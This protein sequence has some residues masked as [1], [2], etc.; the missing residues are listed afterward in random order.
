MTG[1]AGGRLSLMTH[2]LFHGMGY[3]SAHDSDLETPG[4]DA[5]ILGRPLDRA[6]HRLNPGIPRDALRRAAR[7]V[8]QPPHE[9]PAAVNESCHRWLTHGVPV[10]YRRRDEPV[11]D[12]IRLVDFEHPENNGWLTAYDYEIRGAG[13]SEI[14]DLVLFVNGLPLVVMAY[15][16]A[17]AGETGDLTVPYERLRDWWRRFPSLFHFNALCIITDGRRARAGCFN[18]AY[19]RYTVWRSIKTGFIEPLGINQLRLVIGGLLEPEVLLEMVRYFTLFQDA[20]VRDHA[21]PAP[22]PRRLK[23]IA[24]YHQ[25][26]A[27]N[28]AVDSA[29]RASAPDGDR[30]CGVVWH[31]QGGGKSLTMLFYAARLTTA[32]Q[33]E[34]PTI[35]VLTD[36][37]DLDGQLFQTF[38]SARRRLSQTPVRAESRSH[39]RELLRRRSGGVIFTTVQKFFPLREDRHPRLSDRSNIFVIADE[40]HRSQ[41][42]FIDGFA[43]HM[44]DALPHASFTGFTGTPLERRDRNTRAVF[45]DYIISYL[46]RHAV[47]DGITVPICYESRWVGDA[48]RPVPDGDAAASFETIKGNR[49]R[50]RIQFICRDLVSHLDRRRNVVPGKAMVVTDSR[51]AA[52]EYYRQIIALHPG[53]HHQNDREGAVKVVITGSPTD[54]ASWRPHIR[55]GPRRRVIGERFKDPKDPLTIVIVCDMWLTGFDVPCLHTL[56]LDKP[57]KDHLL[58]QAMA[59]VNRVFAGKSDGLVVDYRGNRS[60]LEKACALYDGNGGDGGFYVTPEQ[61]VI[62]LKRV[63]DTLELMVT[64]ERAEKE[65]LIPEINHLFRAFALAAPHPEA[66]R[67]TERIEFFRSLKQSLHP[68][69]P[70]GQRCKG[71][72]AFLKKDSLS[73]AALLRIAEVLKK[74]IR[75]R[76]RRN[77]V[78]FREAS[79]RVERALNAYRRTRGAPAERMEALEHICRAARDMRRAEQ[80][81]R[82]LQLTPEQLALYDALADCPPVRARFPE[83]EVRAVARELHDAIQ[84]NITADWAVRES[85]RA[86]LRVTVKRTLR[87]RQFPMEA[88][89][90]VLQQAEVQAGGK[91][92]ISDQS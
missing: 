32:P 65:L 70:P 73:E 47:A 5:P 56:Y 63:L 8:F 82:T 49:S 57:L 84:Q 35:V 75:R 3:R 30:R 66:L 28:A 77:I 7:Q 37:N 86:R 11:Y 6:L 92:E 12:T 91:R 62:R 39:L 87:L 43:R 4:S 51:R 42:D 34:N 53:R 31:T 81:T 79:A 54:P 48:A 14:L 44:R 1:P 60:R 9:D 50:R 26:H 20:G 88:L 71:A 15:T 58:L 61:A 27:V 24:M 36:R 78:R 2:S 69:R 19:H 72:S 13:D 85:A 80:R 41:Y 45:G 38:V 29:F 25:Y 64:G 59:R 89:D 46:S 18:A 68:R 40:A 17:E 90:T 55:D 67:M 76:G 74:E 10:N 83:P 16:A 21:G 52:I 33:L 23:K 22:A